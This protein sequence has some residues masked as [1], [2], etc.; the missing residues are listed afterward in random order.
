MKFNCTIFAAFLIFCT[1]CFA[2]EIPAG[3]E[4]IKRKAVLHKNS[5]IV[6]PNKFEK[7]SIS[8]LDVFDPDEPNS[9]SVEYSLGK[10]QITFYVYPRNVASKTGE[11]EFI[12]LFSTA[13]ENK[14]NLSVHQNTCTTINGKSKSL[15]AYIGAI[16]WN[17]NH[18]SFGNWLFL[19]PGKNNYYYIKVTYP[20]IKKNI[21]STKELAADML[22]KLVPEES[23]CEVSEN[24]ELFKKIENT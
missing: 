16:S 22:L 3:F 7:Y 11:L 9:A 24:S 13:K 17:E 23:D 12:S 20:F 15:K 4:A 5:G 21:M 19:A 18:H 14:A 8:K 6:F 10:I 2:L 1:N